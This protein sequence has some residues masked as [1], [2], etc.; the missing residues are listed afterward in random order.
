MSATTTT[1][2]PCPELARCGGCAWMHR[3]LEEQRQ[4]LQDDV[5]RAISHPVDELVP[6]PRTEGYRLRLRLR[7]GPDGRLGLTRPRSHEAVP[8]A[9]CTVAHPRLNEVLG[10][11]PELPGFAAVE[12]RTNGRDVVLAASS[13]RRAGPRQRR[14]PKGGGEL[15]KRLVALDLGGLGLAGV[16]LDGNRIAGQPRL[17]LG[18]EGGEP[19]TGLQASAGSFFQVNR[20]IN[21]AV[22]ARVGAVVR[23]LA[24][25]HLLDLY[26]GN[27]NLSLGLAGQG[28]GLTLIESSPSAVR[29]AREAVARRG[30][31]DTVDVQRGDAGAFQP[32][33][34]FFDVA[35]LDPPRAGAPGL[36]ARLLTTRPRA[37]LYLSC[38]PRALGRDLGALRGSAWRLAHT[39]VY[40]MFPHTGHAEVLAVVLRDDQPLPV[41]ALGATAGSALRDTAPPL[42]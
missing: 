36:L 32:G 27:G 24:P 10:R 19:G 12:L 8:L 20:A 11:L 30:L 41:E 13:R 4:Q 6:S 31:Q 22:V 33:D 14:G 9:S 42:R 29:D 26:A 2:P 16:A 25:A 7:P 40:E 39:T 18:G 34:C 5:E 28:F 38:N 15:R 37:L 35:V 21:A 17:E 3:S 1:A 23:G